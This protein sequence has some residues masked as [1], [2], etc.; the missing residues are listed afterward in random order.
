MH[1][2]ECC[3]HLHNSNNEI[4]YTISILTAHFS[5][6]YYIPRLAGWRKGCPPA[7]PRSFSC[8]HYHPLPYTFTGCCLHSN[9]PLC[10]SGWTQAAHGMWWGCVFDQHCVVLTLNIPYLKIFDISPRQYTFQCPSCILSIRKEFILTFTHMS[11]CMYSH[12]VS[13]L[14]NI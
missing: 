11:S 13:L 5:W 2:S 6:V 10:S 9:H 8:P 1:I 12:C 7:T 3:L 14:M 4:L